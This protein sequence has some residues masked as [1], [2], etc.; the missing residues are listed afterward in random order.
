[1]R[2]LGGVSENI[3]TQIPEEVKN[4]LEKYKDEGWVSQE[5]VWGRVL[6]ANQISVSQNIR[7][8]D[9]IF[10]FQN[11]YFEPITYRSYQKMSPSEFE[12]FIKK[13][14]HRNK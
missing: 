8:A 13:S 4:I 14:T 9:P 7:G 12:D 2:L 1:M 5:P 3:D 10:E 6:K 11:G